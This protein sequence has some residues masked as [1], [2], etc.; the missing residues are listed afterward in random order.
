MRR[1]EQH[2]A[3]AETESEGLEASEVR[4]ASIFWLIDLLGDDSTT[5]LSPVSRVAMPTEPD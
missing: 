2:V 1:G 4:S 3:Q 5:A